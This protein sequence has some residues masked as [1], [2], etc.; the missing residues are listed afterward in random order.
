[1]NYWAYFKL[2]DGVYDVVPTNVDVKNLKPAKIRGG[3]KIQSC[4]T[5]ESSM[6]YF[7][8]RNYR[9]LGNSLEGLQSRG[10]RDRDCH[11]F[12]SVNKPWCNPDS[13]L[14]AAMGE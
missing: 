14:L 1:M 7:K 6:F 13:D 12:F 5:C 3:R 4:F 9:V 2:F 10:E 11:I 8:K